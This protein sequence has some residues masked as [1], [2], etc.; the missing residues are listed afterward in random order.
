MRWLFLSLL[1]LSACDQTLNSNSSDAG[2]YADVSSFFTAAKAIISANCAGCHPTYPGLSEAD[3]KA[4]GL[5]VAGNPN[6]SM[7]YY[8]LVGS[9]GTNGPK[10]MP[11]GGA[12]SASDVAAIATWIQNITP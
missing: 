7:I 9:A 11:Q 12:L 10:T 4:Q 6:S 1:F 8:R 3:F 2:K 5:V